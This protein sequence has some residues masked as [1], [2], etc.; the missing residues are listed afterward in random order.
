MKYD[1]DVEYGVDGY[2]IDTTTIDEGVRCHVKD[3]RSLQEM[4]IDSSNVKP[5]PRPEVLQKLGECINLD[6]AVVKLQRKLSFMDSPVPSRER[7][8]KTLE[9]AKDLAQSIFPISF[10]GFTVTMDSTPIAIVI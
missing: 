3:Y 6:F 8:A 4:Q 1:T 5:E 10:G 7:F 2:L 9:L